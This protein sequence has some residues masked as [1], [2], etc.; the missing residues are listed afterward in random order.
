MVLALPPTATASIEFAPALDAGVAA[1]L[2]SF[3]P[4]DV[5]KFLVRYE[6]PFWLDLATSPTVAF[7][8]PAGLYIGDASRRDD[9]TLVVFLGGP[10]S[11][12]WQS[13]AHDERRHRLMAH[14]VAAYGPAA[15][16]PVEVIE[17]HWPAD[18]WGGGGYWNVLVDVSTDAIEVLRR[19][20]P[21]ITF[22]S[23]ELAPSFPG[24]VEGAITAGRAGASAVLAALQR[25][26][27]TAP[28]SVPY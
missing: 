7:V 14:L 28:R 3:V 5:S 22:C 9:P 10:M 19:G 18:R 15:A 2:D 23:T 12:A 11:H 6:Q 27:R 16:H 1:A 4:G 17:R 8:D 21:G 20:A 25:H 24:Y 26:D 13:I